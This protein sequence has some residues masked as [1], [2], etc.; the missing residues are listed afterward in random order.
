M[1]QIQK[2]SILVGN[3]SVGTV[4]VD[5]GG[6]SGDGNP[7]TPQLS[8]PVS[9]QM[10]TTPAES[11]V[12]VIGLCARLSSESTPSPAAT[13]C[14]PTTALLASGFPVRSLPTGTLEHTV[15]MRFFLAA[16]QVAA[17]ERHRHDSSGDV[18]TLYLHVEL[19]VGG[20]I[21][22]N[23]MNPGVDTEKTPWDFQF[24]MFSQVLPFWNVQVQPVIVAIEQSKWIRDVLPGFGHDRVRLMEMRFP[25]PAA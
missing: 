16:E 23:Q 25:P 11:M 3:H 9:I 8:I 17:L 24:G 19:V 18:F 4:G 2:Q 20:L 15:V 12:A 14:P 1:P 21:T 13:V 7:S 6:V 5:G 22:H 10:H